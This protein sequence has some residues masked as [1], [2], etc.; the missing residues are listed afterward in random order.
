M[1]PVTSFFVS[2]QKWTTRIDVAQGRILPTSA[3]Y[4]HRAYGQPWTAWCTAQ[5]QRYGA[6]L[7]VVKLG[8]VP[9]G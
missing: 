9:N 7:R 6:T 2:T 4:H 5:A 1:P 3:R 8:E